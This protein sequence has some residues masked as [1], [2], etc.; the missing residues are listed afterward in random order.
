MLMSGSNV[1]AEI[2]RSSEIVRAFVARETDDRRD[3]V[4]TARGEDGRD[5]VRQE[6]AVDHR[7]NRYGSRAP[8]P[9]VLLQRQNLVRRHRAHISDRRRPSVFWTSSPIFSASASLGSV[10][11]SSKKLRV[12]ANPCWNRSLASGLAPLAV[13][14]IT[15]L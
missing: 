15:N 10:S 1:R 6:I 9:T 12:I 13:T 8:K 5:S 3:V 11:R 14:D 2:D 7:R 4:L